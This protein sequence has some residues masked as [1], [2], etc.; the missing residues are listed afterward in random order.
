MNG[1]APAGL[2]SSGR[3]LPLTSRPLTELD[4]AGR[5]G[6]VGS[7]YLQLSSRRLTEVDCAGRAGVV[8]SWWVHCEATRGAGTGVNWTELAGLASS[9]PGG[10]D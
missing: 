1:T 4:C 7:S 3:C 2:A 8:G 9:G 10:F 6:V 5:A